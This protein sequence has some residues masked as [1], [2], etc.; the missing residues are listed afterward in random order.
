MRTIALLI[1][2]CLTGCA[3]RDDIGFLLPDQKVTWAEAVNNQ[4]EGYHIP[5]ASELQK[6]RS[7]YDIE[8]S[9]NNLTSAPTMLWTSDKWA[10]AVSDGAKH[11]IDD[12]QAISVLYI[13]D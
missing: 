1:G 11:R 10:V 3:T 2:L 9:E 12:D 5:T 7:D 8:L 6:L 13:G 4:P